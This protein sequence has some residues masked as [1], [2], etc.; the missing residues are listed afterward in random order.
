MP[1]HNFYAGRPPDPGS[2]GYKLF[3]WDSDA[4]RQY[5]RNKDTKEGKGI[6]LIYLPLGS[7]PSASAVAP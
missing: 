3:N 1:G 6:E 5:S 2:T 7:T 4:T